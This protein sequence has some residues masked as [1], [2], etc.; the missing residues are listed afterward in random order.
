MGTD[1]T[2]IVGGKLVEKPQ[3]VGIPAIRFLIYSCDEAIV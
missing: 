2:P 1:H 3:P